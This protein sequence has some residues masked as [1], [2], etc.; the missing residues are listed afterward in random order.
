[1]KIQLQNVYCYVHATDP[2]E[3]EALRS[4]L[5]VKEDARTVY[6]RT[7]KLRG[8]K[9]KPQYKKLL[10]SNNS[11]Y[12]GF[13]PWV[14]NHMTGLGYKVSIFD[15]RHGMLDFKKPLEEVLHTE[16][17]LTLRDYQL[18]IVKQASHFEKIGE[19]T[20]YFPRGIISAATNAG[21]TAIA[22]AIVQ[23][24]EGYPRT[25]YLTHRK[26]I[27]TQCIDF[28]S[29]LFDVGFV[30]SG[31]SVKLAS[32]M[33]CM[34]QSLRARMVVSTQVREFV[35]SANVLIVDECHRFGA[36]TYEEVV[37]RLPAAHRYFMSGTPLARLEKHGNWLLQGM[38][39]RVFAEVENRE[40]IERKISLKVDIRMVRMNHGRTMFPDYE[41]E[42]ESNLYSCYPKA[43][44]VSSLLQMH[45]DR[46]VLVC[47]RIIK[48]GQFV[49]N[50]CKQQQRD[51]NQLLD[52]EIV[53]GASWNR[54]SAI[55]NFKKGR[56][57][58]LFSST[59]LQEG[60]DIADIEVIILMLGTKSETILKQFIGRGLR[61]GGNYDTLLV[62]DFLDN[63]N[64]LRKHSLKRLN[65]YKKEGFPVS[66]YDKTEQYE[67][68]P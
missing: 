5:R 64:H 18:E 33:V 59:I 15:E 29:Q 47:Y 1:M 20:Y 32:F 28:F 56:T 38:S 12:T 52:M 19:I 2:H 25:V 27:Y 31:N 11:F 4:F 17:G 45:S 16:Q 42:L 10:Y 49:Y 44:L 35:E 34:V 21:K 39:G 60:V 13:L 68:K 26:E 23:N 66:Y 8:F 22:A 67:T 9:L 3:I 36:K 30:S 53:H 14:Y 62:Y 37:S 7:R 6:F 58:V 46:R 55:Q 43:L 40:L 57:A 41:T 65:L 54:S 48:H 50:V 24:L 51:S 63:S 61:S